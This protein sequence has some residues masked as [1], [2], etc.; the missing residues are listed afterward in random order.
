MN[1]TPLS[2]DAELFI[3]SWAKLQYA[4]L[5]NPTDEIT[6]D[7]KRDVAERLQRDFSITELQLLA[8]AE[9]F[10]TVSFKERE[11]TGF[12]QFSTDEI[13]SLI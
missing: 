9:S 8:R 7:A 4:T 6:L 11:E 13:E 12:L 2:M 5:L 3:L 10:Y 1:D